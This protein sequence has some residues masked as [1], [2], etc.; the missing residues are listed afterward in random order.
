MRYRNVCNPIELRLEQL[1]VYYSKAEDLLRLY[2]NTRSR[3]D[4]QRERIEEQLARMRQTR[5]RLGLRPEVDE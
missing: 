4:R 2:R 5:S 3:C 1:K